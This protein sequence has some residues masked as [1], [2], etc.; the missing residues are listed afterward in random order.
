MVK[1]AT[2]AKP[3]LAS[4]DESIAAMPIVVASI[5]RPSLW[6]PP[7]TWIRT[8]GLRTTKAAAGRGATPRAGARRATRTAAPRTAK[9]AVA[10]SVATAHQTGNQ[11]SG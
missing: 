6:A 10:F 4:R 1:A 2:K 11:A 7:T 8:S 3:A 5:A 9:A